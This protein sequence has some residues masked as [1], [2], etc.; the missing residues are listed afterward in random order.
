MSSFGQ[1]G[2]VGGGGGG[3]GGDYIELI[4]SAPGGVDLSGQ[5]KLCSQ[6][7]LSSVVSFSV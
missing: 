5:E 6:S 2:L 3:G 4:E 7:S 1:P